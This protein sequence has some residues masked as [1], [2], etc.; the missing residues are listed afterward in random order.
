MKTVCF[1]LQWGDEGK[2]KVT[3][4]LSKEY[5]YVVRYSGGS[6][7]G[8]TVEYGDFKLVHHLVPS[9]DVR[10]GVKG[11]ISNGVVVD[12]N[13]IDKEIE[14][15][16]RIGFDI[17]SKLNI[18]AFAHVVL[19]VHKILDEKMEL[20][21]GDK[22]VGT[23]KRGI[24]PTYADR[25]H[26][27]GI[28]L[29][30]F[31]DKYLLAEKFSTINKIYKELYD[32]EWNNYNSVIEQYDRI[33]KLIISPL[34]MKK[35]L[36][37]SNVLFEGTQGV[38][39]DV[40]MGTYPYVTG[41]FCNTTGVESGLGYKINLDKRIGIFKAYITRVGEGPFPTELFGDEGE[42]LRQAGKEFGAT[43]GRPRRC[44]WLDLPLLKYAIE[45]SGCDEMIMTKADV[46]A[47]MEK[48]KVGVRY[49]INGKKI[50]MPYNLSKID[51]AQVEYA[52]FKGWNSLEDKEFQKFVEFIESETGVKI[53]YIST[54]AK[55][56]QV[57]T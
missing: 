41:T 51:K 1:G 30:D 57:L 50:E 25:V 20:V 35:D 45:I 47:G 49:A 8:H 22:A 42:I 16:K 14:E 40:D 13:V 21:K 27:I 37:N 46:L 44:G 19:P 38:L 3:T 48:I 52:E 6:N 43:T 26:R 29:A 32:I 23:T 36:E 5:D 4:Y 53:T 11:Y 31:E 34:E 7:A 10:K 33:S 28:R 12:L 2:G 18:S 39:L 55:V 15:L 56:D 24:G 17:S 54:G 9:F